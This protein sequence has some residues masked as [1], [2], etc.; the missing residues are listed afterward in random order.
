[1]YLITNDSDKN[2]FMERI[3]M[4]YIS[5]D[6]LDI[7]NMA[8]KNYPEP[9]AELVQSIMEFGVQEPV[10]VWNNAVTDGIQRVRIVRELREAGREIST[11]VPV[12]S[13][14][15]YEDEYNSFIVDKILDKNKGSQILTSVLA[16][17]ILRYYSTVIC[18]GQRNDLKQD[19]T[20]NPEQR[21][22]N[23]GLQKCADKFGL[24]QRQISRY[25]R[26]PNC[27][28]M[29]LDDIDSGKISLRAAVELSFMPKD[30]QNRVLSYARG[31]VKFTVPKAK[32]CRLSYQLSK[33]T[34][35][36]FCAY[37]IVHTLLNW[38]NGKLKELCE[39]EKEIRMK[40]VVPR[41]ETNPAL[42]DILEKTKNDRMELESWEIVEEYRNSHKELLWH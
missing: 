37:G 28:S 17:L 39:K 24:S 26:L 13:I 2:T 4:R 27:A 38:E 16:E 1:M 34:N 29:V 23:A 22:K 3:K 35:Q 40:N 15:M 18:Q 32:Y 36:Q 31:K 42:A 10:L 6:D 21:I 20:D 7:T 9:N 25:I 33:L 19:K 5:V 30:C 8:E 11:L 41:E 14:Q 12:K